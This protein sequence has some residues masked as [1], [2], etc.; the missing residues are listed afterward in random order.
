MLSLQEGSI[1]KFVNAGLITADFIFLLRDHKDVGG[2]SKTGA[3]L[4]SGISNTQRSSDTLSFIVD[5]P[6]SVGFLKGQS[7]EVNGYVDTYAGLNGSYVITGVTKGVNLSG[8]ELSRYKIDVHSAGVDI[9]AFESNGVTLKLPNGKVRIMLAGSGGAGGLDPDSVA[10]FGGNTFS[11]ITDPTAVVLTPTIGLDAPLGAI[12]TEIGDDELYWK[13][14]TG[15][16]H[17]LTHGGLLGPTGRTG[18]TGPLGPT[19]PTGVQGSTGP[20]GPTGSKG[21]TGS[22]G[23]VGPTGPQYALAYNYAQTLSGITSASSGPFVVATVTLTSYGY[24]VQVIATGD[25][26]PSSG[27]SWTRLQLYRDSTPIGNTV[28]AE[29]SG[30]NENVPYAL[31]VI[32]EVAAGTYVYK[33]VATSVTGTFTFGEAAGPVIT[34]VEINGAVGPTGLIG[35]V[36]PTG[37]QGDIGLTGPTGRAGLNGSNGSQGPT[38]PTGPA[39]LNGSNGSQ[40]PTG[41]TGSV[42]PTGSLGATGPSGLSSVRFGNVL[43]VDSVNGND[44]SGAVNGNP[45]LTVTGAINYIN[46]HSL[47]GVTV[48]IM[49]GTYA[50]SSGITVPDTCSL[51]GLSLQTTKLTLTASNPGGTVTMLT[52]GENTRVEDLSL[53]L[54]STNSTTSLVG[55]ALPGN[56]S[57]TSK[58]RTC[59]ITVDNSTLTATDTTNVYGI[60]TIGSG[61]L[62]SATFSFNFIK[63][64][65]LNVKSNGIGNKFGLYMPDGVGYANQLSTRDFNI[66]VAPPTTS[67]STG[68]Y[69]GVYTD[70]AD[71]Q[72]QFRSTSISGA[73]YPAVQP[74]LPVNYVSTSNITLS[75]TYS[76]QGGT[77]VVG[78][79]VLAA[80]QTVGTNNGI[81]VVASGAWTRSVDM[82]AGSP[83]LGAYTF[84]EGGTYT[85][86]GWE[87]TTN[88]NVGAGS[89]SFVQR[90][91]G[92]DILQN[93]PQA[94]NG[95]NGIQMGPGSDLVTKTAGTH[96]FTT[97]VTPTTLQFCLRSNV[98]AGVHYM[99]PGTLVNSLD[100]TE[101]FYRFQQ[102]SIL[103]GMFVNLRTAPGTN[104]SLTVTVNLSKTGVSGTGAATFMKCTVSG[105]ETSANNYLSSV[106]G[107]QYDYI[108]V[109]VD[110]SNGSSAADL[111]VELDLY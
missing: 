20:T 55:I 36:G 83:S 42:G 77:L 85:H 22:T 4:A 56:T 65:T 92:S 57:V 86:T 66:Y 35:A 1:A 84:C 94:G 87:C 19:G 10:Y 61:V 99:W 88:L 23:S 73:P 90:Y 101:C 46:T 100:S 64:S 82:A 12:Y 51:R 40:G 33:L 29:S 5:Y 31:N 62:S 105:S 18:P 45:F 53:T 69:V 98:E 27:G 6:E 60:Y 111:V 43:I 97:Y 63:G 16:I 11:L 24:P 68:L 107:A 37:P 34:A 103:Q 54:T 72:V 89:L 39:G 59:V 3:P 38:G 70:N 47:T 21:D 91:A 78:N 95:S 2:T 80:G 8:V 96:P 28:Q 81:W 44:G 58:V 25:A 26:N 52:M 93:S 104:K 49:P 108:S 75:G 67:S 13:D 110:C 79:R 14:Q 50:L 76:L 7:I 74:K 48:W 15:F 30:A 17:A 106:D 32:D 109:Q 71:S 102:R 41:P 9:P